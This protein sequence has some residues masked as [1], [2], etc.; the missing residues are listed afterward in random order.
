MSRVAWS[1]VCLAG[2][3]LTAG[4][5]SKEIIITQYP[6]FYTDDM[7]GMSIAVAPFQ[8]ATQDRTAGDVIADRLSSA[9]DGNGTYK[10]YNSRYLKTLMDERNLQMAVAEDP[11]KAAEKFRQVKALNAHA[12][13][14]GTVTTY[15]ATQR[16]ER[17]QD[18]QYIYNPNTQRNE[19][20]GYRVYTLTRNEANVTVTA[21]LVRLKD[22]AAIH[23]TDR[24]AQAQA[25]AQGSPPSMDPFA[26]LTSASENVVA[27]LVE[28]FAV[29]RKKIKVDPRKA[30]RTAD[31]LYDNKWTFAEKFA[32]SD[33]EMFVVVELP[34]SCD[35]NRF[36]IVI[37]RRDAR[38][39]LAQEDIIW[40]RKYNS[41]GYKFNPSEIAGKGGGPGAYTVKFYSGP[42]PVF[43]RDFKIE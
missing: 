17:K 6:E 14:M 7:Q 39:P 3:V 4:G 36:R 37:V 23:T 33:K 18:P 9:L 35:R 28:E 21:T 8:N 20:A 27:Q 16:N 29:V 13:L 26:C 10:V 34:A 40:T 31:E 15:A 38:E 22:G 42:E 19:F 32:A 43:T 11:M 12:I 25:W 2:L 30:L 1:F 24:P 41:F 5:C